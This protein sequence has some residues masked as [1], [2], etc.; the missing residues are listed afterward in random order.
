[1]KH[2]LTT[3]N[4]MSGQARRLL[5]LPLLTLL[6]GLLILDAGYVLMHSAAPAQS[7]TIERSNYSAQQAAQPDADIARARSMPVARTARGPIAAPPVVPTAV[8]AARLSNAKIA[9]LV[10]EPTPATC[11]SLTGRLVT[12]TVRSAVLGVNLPVHVYLP[13]CYN[14]RKHIYPAIYLFR[15]T[16]G[17]G[18]WV[19]NGLPEVADLQIGLGLLPPFIAVMPATDESSANG[20]K[21]RYSSRGNGSWEDFIVN[22]LLPAIERK[23]SVWQ[24]PAGRAIGGIS[25]GAYWSIEIAFQH[26]DLFGIVGGHSPAIT[27]DLLIGTPAGF[28]MLSMA[29]S[30][31]EIKKLR[32]HLDAGDRD[33]AQRGVRQLSADLSGAGIAHTTSA[34]EGIHADGYWKSRMT[35]YLAFY[36]AT[37]PRIPRPK[38]VTTQPVVTSQLSEP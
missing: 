3:P 31:D 21:F 33:W 8:T 16:D 27:S 13:P 29:R 32:I 2:T 30:I 5:R 37:W 35:D 18:N 28:S 11:G 19:E 7:E 36:T 10:V 17:Y 9:P 38:P 23:Y 14:D 6:T 20:G 12:E 15:G 24:T 25:R 22:E 4:S 34:G 1:M 26:P